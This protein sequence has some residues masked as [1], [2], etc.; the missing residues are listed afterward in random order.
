MQD[1]MQS[2]VFDL[3]EYPQNKRSNLDLVNRVLYDEGI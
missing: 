3:G 2:Q 1:N